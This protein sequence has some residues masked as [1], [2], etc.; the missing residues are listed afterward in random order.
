MPRVLGHEVNQRPR[1]GASRRAV[2]GGRCDL[3]A[4]GCVLLISF[5]PN[6]RNIVAL[7]LLAA[8]IAFGLYLTVQLNH[9][10]SGTV[11][12]GPEAFQQSPE[13]FQ[14]RTGLPQRVN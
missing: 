6:W 1:P 4:L 10:L 7:E 8:E 11:H 9:P 5:P 3:V 14:T 13:R 2:R 12:I